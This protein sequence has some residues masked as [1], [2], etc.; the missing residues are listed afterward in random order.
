M[1]CVKSRVEVATRF[2]GRSTK[3]ISS[4]GESWSRL[5]ACSKVT[6]HPRR[7]I[8]TNS[9]W[10]HEY[11]GTQWERADRCA[12][13]NLRPDDLALSSMP[14]TQISGTTA[15]TTQLAASCQLSDHICILVAVEQITVARSIIVELHELTNITAR[16]AYSVI[17]S[18]TRGYMYFVQTARTSR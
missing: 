11:M 2:T 18:R 10:V 1:A 3:R 7:Y 14:N 4:L 16:I 15:P 5:H 17:S 8:I 13:L 12:G 6:N 9:E